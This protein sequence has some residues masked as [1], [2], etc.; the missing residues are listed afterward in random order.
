MEGER[1]KFS[2]FL[3]WQ[4]A[5][6]G[7]TFNT[8]HEVWYSTGILKLSSS[9]LLVYNRTVEHG[10]VAGVVTATYYIF[11]RIV[12]FD[13]GLKHRLSYMVA[14]RTRY[15][16]NEIHQTFDDSLHPI[17]DHIPWSKIWKYY[18]PSRASLTIWRALHNSLPIAELLWRRG[19]ATSPIFQILPISSAEDPTC[20]PG[21]SDCCCNLEKTI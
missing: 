10:G 15:L 5:S 18:G 6:G 20:S 11:T 16:Q 14:Y 2:L 13:E 19:I 1:W 12:Q 21:L 4:L 9:T 7:R 3:A 8:S 17:R